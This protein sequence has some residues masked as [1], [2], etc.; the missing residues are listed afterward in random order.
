VRAAAQCRKLVHGNSGFMNEIL[1]AREI[2]GLV[3]PPEKYR[4]N[5]DISKTAAKKYSQIGAHKRSKEMI[6]KIF[7]EAAQGLRNRT[8]GTQ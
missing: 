3:G 5:T 8:Q 7:S 2:A 1:V 4:V 6:K